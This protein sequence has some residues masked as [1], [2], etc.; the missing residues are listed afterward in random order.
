M[1]T[2]HTDSSAGSLVQL[3]STG[4][5]EATTQDAHGHTV[6]L[7]KYKKT[8]P[9]AL[10]WVTS[11]IDNLGF[12]RKSS[13]TVHR[14]ADLMGQVFIV[15]ELPGLC[16]HEELGSCTFQQYPV[17]CT[18]CK[19]D[20][21]IGG[22]AAVDECD[23]ADEF[24]GGNYAYWC[25]ATGYA[26]VEEASIKV[27]GQTVDKHI[28]EYMFIY[29]ELTG[30]A[31]KR[32]VEMVNRHSSLVSLICASQNPN[33]IRMFIPLHFWFCRDLSQYFPMAAVQYHNVKFEMCFRKL[34]ELIIVSKPNLSVAALGGGSIELDAHMT[35][36]MVYLGSHERD[37]LS[38]KPFQHVIAQLQ[39][40]MITTT[41]TTINQPLYFNLAVKAYQ[42]AVRRGCNK[43]S[44]NWFNFS[45]YNGTD[46]VKSVQV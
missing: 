43:E 18:S 13:V 8:T 24:N 25:N 42:F 35:A 9:F 36:R 15:V 1:P 6:F 16:V 7:A 29:E 5:V 46:A 23:C 41:A 32:V 40:T 31:G 27:G 30:F 37:L 11:T 34:S 38:T 12:G 44:N 21:H 28:S 4:S 20:E 3:A 17:G 22:C 19:A 33:G 2:C 39:H 10:D 45:G 14:V 26:L